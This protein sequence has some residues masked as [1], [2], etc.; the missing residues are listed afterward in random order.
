MNLIR[1][2]TLALIIWLVYR[3][4]SSYRLSRSRKHEPNT[5]IKLA[6]CDHCGAMAAEII[7]DTEGNAYCSEAHRNLGSSQRKP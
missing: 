2:L 3:L 6:R 5:T 7:T 4:I 1:I